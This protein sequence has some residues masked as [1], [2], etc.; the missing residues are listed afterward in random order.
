MECH[1]HC[2]ATRTLFD[3]YLYGLMSSVTLAHLPSLHISGDGTGAMLLRLIEA[4]ALESFSY[5]LHPVQNNPIS[6]IPNNQMTKLVTYPYL[7]R[8]FMHLDLKDLRELQIKDWSDPVAGVFKDDHLQSLETLII[9]LD[10]DYTNLWFHDDVLLDMIASKRIIKPDVDVALMKSVTF[11][12]ARAGACLSD[13]SLMRLKEMQK[14]GLELTFVESELSSESWVWSG[15]EMPGILV[16]RCIPLS[17]V[18]E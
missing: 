10:Q 5:L 4:P 18:L 3:D 7:F 8:C 16:H 17:G 11:I 6:S 14:G 13:E 15:I 9:C 2:L 12:D 1:F